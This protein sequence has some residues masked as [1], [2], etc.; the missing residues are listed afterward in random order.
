[1]KEIVMQRLDAVDFNKFPRAWS[2]LGFWAQ[3]ELLHL[4][5]TPNPVRRY[6]LLRQKE[7]ED[8]MVAEL[9]F[10]A[11][12][13]SIEPLDDSLEAL[14][15][16]K[17]SLQ[18]NSPSLQHVYQ[19]WQNYVYLAL[20]AYE[21]PFVRITRDTNDDWLY[22]G[23]FRDRFILADTLDTI[24]KILRLPRC[25]RGKWPCDKLDD[26]TCS[27]WCR[28]LDE[29]YEN[30]D[31]S[32]EKLDALLKESFLKPSGGVLEM[33]IHERD[34]YFDELEFIK[35][36]LLADEIEIQAKYRD[37][38][39]FLYVARQLSWEDER[40]QV[41][42]G[43]LIKVKRP[44]REYHFLPDNTEYRENESLAIN[45][46]SVDEARILY[47]WWMSK[48]KGKDDV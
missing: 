27:G 14:I 16:Y 12:Q 18:D 7:E 19:P 8:S 35:A 42:N 41:Q 23:P 4:A 13:L 38:L 21:F 45:L 15:R 40:I 24:C 37:W 47:D 39:K 22:L 48:H 10:K 17:I 3:G 6:E 34:K 43:R 26:G 30:P 32:L 11:E 25:E 9:F 2:L 33:L 1:M 46:D 44:H 29:V 20:N 31:C 36:D 5:L 28:S